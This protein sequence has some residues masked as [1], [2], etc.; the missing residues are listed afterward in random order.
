M[1]AMLRC[2]NNA[3]QR[4]HKDYKNKYAVDTA[5][6]FYLLNA[7]STFAI[8]PRYSTQCVDGLLSEKYVRKGNDAK[9]PAILQVFVVFESPVKC[10][11]CGAARK[12]ET[13]YFCRNLPIS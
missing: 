2:L 10:I 3:I 12:I 11:A 7:R 6:L 8:F 4:A 1:I 9:S 13:E 5:R